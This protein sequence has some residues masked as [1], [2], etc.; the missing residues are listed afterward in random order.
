[1]ISLVV[2]L[3]LST[4]SKAPTAVEISPSAPGKDNA[5]LA[6][7]LEK[8]QVAHKAPLPTAPEKVAALAKDDAARLTRVVEIYKADLLKTGADYLAAATILEHGKRPEDFLL[9]HELAVV[10]GFLGE[11]R[12][13]WI[14]AVSEDRFLRSLGRDQRFGTQ[15]WRNLQKNHN[16]PWEV[17]PLDDGVTDAV[18]KLM[19]VPSLA[20]SHAREKQ[21]NSK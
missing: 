8:D 19:K 16:G 2:V 11:K 14:A 4:G 6:A 18:R 12:A 15:Y 21:M 17:A 20:E 13:P 7:L 1:M 5:E 9:A 10:A 3:V